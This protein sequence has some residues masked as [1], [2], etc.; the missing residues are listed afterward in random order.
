MRYTLTI[1]INLPRKKV[2]DF[3]DNEENLKEWQPGLQ[4]TEHLSGEPGKE[5]AKTKM[6]YKMGKREIEMIETIK[7]NQLPERIDTTYDASGV[8]NLQENYFIELDD[9]ITQWKSVCEFRFNNLTM[10]IMGWLMPGA[11]K[12]QS[13]KYMELFK[14]FAE[15]SN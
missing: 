6:F 7:L 4:K 2:I 11:F 8:L 14:Q 13:W 3:F 1:D 12:K 10:K 9:N 5:G 15:S